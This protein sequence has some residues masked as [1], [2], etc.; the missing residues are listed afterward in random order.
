MNCP[1]CGKKLKVKHMSLG[2][3]VDEIKLACKHCTTGVTL[4]QLSKN[5]LDEYCKQ[6]ISEMRE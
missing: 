3:F 2:R 1:R 5:E 4:E 6:F